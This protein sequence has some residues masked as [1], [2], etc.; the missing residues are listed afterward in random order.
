MITTTKAKSKLNSFE[1][2]HLLSDSQKTLLRD[3]I[4]GKKTLTR[5]M[6]NDSKLLGL[7]NFIENALARHGF[8]AIDQANGIIGSSTV[9]AVKLL[10]AVYGKNPKKSVLLDSEVMLCLMDGSLA[11]ISKSVTKSFYQ[12][13][14]EQVVKNGGTWHDAEGFLN[15]IGV[16]G[17]AISKDG[18]D[19]YD[20]QNVFDIYNDAIFWCYKKDGKEV[21]ESYVG[22]VDPGL[23]YKRI[24]PLN[25]NG[26]AHLANGTWL[27]QRGLHGTAQYPALVQAQK[28]KV[29]RTNRNEYR[30]T[31]YVDIGYF[32]INHH[33]GSHGPTVSN[34][35]A[36]CIVLKCGGYRS[37]V[38][39][40]YINRLYSFKNTTFPLTITDSI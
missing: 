36:G 5:D 37:K 14:K 21:V 10:L 1:F 12:R 16:R 22:S 11:A 4:D 19:G 7:S 6:M 33:A 34:A 23:Y 30:P 25:K 20:I 29:Y 8:L 31:D 26:C 24:R 28:F 2:S 40:N 32:G 27:F 17:Y 35:S 38:W 39:V 13:A 18:K 9:E 15:I 3:V